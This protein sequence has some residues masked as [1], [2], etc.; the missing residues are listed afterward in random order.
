MA[1][2][3]VLLTNKQKIEIYERKLKGESLSS[4]ASEFNINVSRLEYLVRLLKKHGYSILRYDKNRYYS[5]EFK[6]LTINRVLINKESIYSVAIDIGLSSDGI[7]IR[8]I[9]KYKENCYNVIEN[10]KGRKPKTMTKP[11]KFKKELTKEDKIK[12]LEEK[13]LYLEAENEYLKKLNALVQEEESAKNK[14]SE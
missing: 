10:K 13:I 4:L 9:K 14:E 8:W 1:K 6:E 7:L 12:E 5:K 11:K 2:Q 3:K